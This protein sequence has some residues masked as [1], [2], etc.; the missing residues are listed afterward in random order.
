M[1]LSRI[2]VVLLAFALAFAACGGGDDDDDGGG[3]S[4]GG[5]TSSA[6]ES[7]DAGPLSFEDVQPN[8]EAAGYT[9]EEEPPE[10]LVRRDDGGIVTP[11]EKLVVSGGELPAG[12]DVSVYSLGSQR[13]VAAVEDLAGGGVSLVEGSIFFQAA[14]PGSAETVA[15]AARG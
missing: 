4:S 2:V 14:E 15:E 8:L 7:A 10:P 3:G 11:E 12:T 6:E 13:D 1:A 5:T 9:V